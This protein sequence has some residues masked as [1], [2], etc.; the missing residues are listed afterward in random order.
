MGCA[1]SKG[2]QVLTNAFATK[3]M[4][5]AM[6][7]AELAELKR[8]HC[9]EIEQALML[10]KKELADAQNRYWLQT[11]T[12]ACRQSTA[13]VVV[14]VLSP[15]PRH[16]G[17]YGTIMVLTQ[18]FWAKVPLGGCSKLLAKQLGRMWPSKFAAEYQRAMT[19]SA[20]VGGRQLKATAKAASQLYESGCLLG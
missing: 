16:S 10:A 4:M 1:S 8:P 5:A 9:P 7:A 15:E 3:S 13:W 14:H 17:V 6:S 2:S 12:T 11:C 19:S 20:E 18:R